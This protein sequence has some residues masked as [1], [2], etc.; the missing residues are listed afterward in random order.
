[1]CFEEVYVAEKGFFLGGGGANTET[2]VFHTI[3]CIVSHK[4]LR[5]ALK[6]HFFVGN[7]Q[8]CYLK[9]VEKDMKLDSESFNF[10]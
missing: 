8:P 3:Q 9:Y 5:H 4:V 6:S 1:M 10:Q 2:I 7:I